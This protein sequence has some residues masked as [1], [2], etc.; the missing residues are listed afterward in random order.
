MLGARL[1]PIRGVGSRFSPAPT[2][3][4]LLE[5]AVT[6][7]RSISSAR[8]SS[9][10]I[11]PWILCQIPAACQS[12][13]RLQHDTPLPQ[14]IS[15]GSISHWMPVRSTKMIP[16]SARRLVMGLRPGY[17]NRRGL[18]G[19]SIGSISVHR[20]SSRIGLAMFV[21]PCTCP[22]ASCPT[23]PS[24][25]SSS[26]PPHADLL[27]LK[28]ALIVVDPGVLPGSATTTTR[29]PCRKTWAPLSAHREEG[30]GNRGPSAAVSTL[31]GNSLHLS[32]GRRTGSASSRPASPVPRARASRLSTLR[33]RPI[34]R[35]HRLPP[36][37]ELP[38]PRPVLRV[39]ARLVLGRSAAP[40]PAASKLVP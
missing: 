14:P 19:G 20:S 29:G 18:G 2:A 36:R 21:P 32:N 5:S 7:D 30:F 15:C 33:V 13:S 17:L 4:T 3:R 6:M 31:R 40:R 28:G 37:Q 39:R 23:T 16:V 10:S 27:F 9:S 1:A 38:A 26:A 34:R 22:R 24:P 8:R 25:R 11:N 35:D 12:R